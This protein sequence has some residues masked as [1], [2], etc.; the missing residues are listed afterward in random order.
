[1]NDLSVADVLVFECIPTQAQRGSYWECGYWYGREEWFAKEHG[2]SPGPT[3]GVFPQGVNTGGT[4][5]DW[6]IPP[7]NKAEAWLDV[8]DMVHKWSKEN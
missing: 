1:M 5:H 3:F 7:V 8:V 6:L 2:W 4:I